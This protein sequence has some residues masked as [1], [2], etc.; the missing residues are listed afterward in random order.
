MQM[1]F[2][3][4]AS[5]ANLIKEKTDVPTVAAVDGMRINFGE[6]ISVQVGGKTRE[7]LNKFF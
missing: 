2:K 3:G 6:T 1:I 7:G 4:P 5:E